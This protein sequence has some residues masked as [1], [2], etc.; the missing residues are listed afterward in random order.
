[1]FLTHLTE[2]GQAGGFPQTCNAA[3]SANELGHIGHFGKPLQHRKVD[4]FGRGDQAFA[5]GLCFQIGD[6]RRDAV[7]TRLGF[8]PIEP[9]EPGKI[10]IFDTAKKCLEQ[11]EIV[12]ITTADP[13]FKQLTAEDFRANGKNISVYDFW[14]ILKDELS[15]KEK[16]EY[17]PIGFSRNDE[18]QSAFLTKL[19]GT[20][21][22]N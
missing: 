14:R 17:I 2:I 7:E 8:A 13:E 4:G 9:V 12:L 18:S 1:M 22:D 20:E 11:A 16:I 3:G 6:K 21:A 19:W 5:G 10:V 15:E